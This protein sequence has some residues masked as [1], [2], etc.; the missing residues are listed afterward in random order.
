MASPRILRIKELNLDMIPPNQKN[1]HKKGQGGVKL[2][3]IGKP[4]TGKCL[5]FL[6]N[7][8]MYD[9]TTKPAGEIQTGDLLMGDDNTSRKVT[10]LF[11]GQD[12]MY[13]IIPQDSTESYSVTGNH[14]LCLRWNTRPIIA[15]ENGKNPRY[16]VF[17]PKTHIDNSTGNPLN[18]VSWGNVG[19]SIEKYGDKQAFEKAK[20]KH[21][22]LTKQYNAEFPLHEV[23]VIN[24]LEQNKSFNHRLVS[25]RTG[26][27]YNLEEYDETINPYLLGVWLGDGNSREPRITNIDRE[28]IDFLYKEA[29][30][31]NLRISQGKDSPLNKDYMNYRFC[32]TSGKKNSNTVLNFLRDYNLLQNK[33]IPHSFKVNSRKNRLELLAGLID[34]DGYWSNKNKYYEI[35]QKNKCLSDDILF[36]IRSLGYW[37]HMREVTKGCMYKGEYRKGTYHRITFGGDNLED[38][39]VLIPRKKAPKSQKR[40]KDALHYKITIEKGEIEDYYGFEV[41]GTNSRFLLGDFTVTHN[42]NLIKSILNH[43]NDIF[44]VGMLMSGT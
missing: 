32:S 7:V 11:R 1:M 37:V 4:G 35:I 23:E 28:I 34:T 10:N 14:I 41:E 39:P 26:V 20:Y 17:Y 8:L 31:M 18:K 19:F 6:T 16:R 21:Q 12:Q 5:S 27:E 38:I 2:T 24:Y 25:Y 9:G 36:L 3:V 42:S 22:I 43:K 30:N 33:H 15:K 44:P 29:E 13:K 40:Q